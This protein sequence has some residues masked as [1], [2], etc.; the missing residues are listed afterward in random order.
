MIS[1]GTKRAIIRWIHIIFG[2]P[3]LGYIYSP[4]EEIPNYAPLFGVSSF[5]QLSFR[6]FVEGWE[7]TVESKAKLAA[8]SSGSAFSR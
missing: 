2:I 6:D 5:L 7:M 1:D 8:P 4:F 3:I